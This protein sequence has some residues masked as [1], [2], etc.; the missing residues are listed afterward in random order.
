MK[1]I[2]GLF[3]YTVIVIGGSYFFQSYE[4]FETILYVLTALSFLF[5]GVSLMPDSFGNDPNRVGVR[6]KFYFQERNYRKTSLSLNVIDALALL[7]SVLPFLVS[8]YLF[9]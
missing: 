7:Y 8:I 1:R 9:A 6:D 4:Y 5:V 2:I 3:I